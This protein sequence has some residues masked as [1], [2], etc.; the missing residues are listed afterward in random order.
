MN[1][2]IY[3]YRF[4][5]HCEVILLVVPLFKYELDNYNVTTCGQNII[6]KS[7]VSV[8]LKNHA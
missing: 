7:R 4:N 2:D 8:F 5:L 6:T 1:Q 3:R